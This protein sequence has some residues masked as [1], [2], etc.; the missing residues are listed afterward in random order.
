MSLVGLTRLLQVGGVVAAEAA[1][2]VQRWH[3][4]HGVG[5]R[6]A[7]I[8]A[9]AK[10]SGAKLVTRETGRFPMDDIEIVVPY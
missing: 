9:T 1:E 3:L 4:S 6:D 7:L 8:A 2:Y 10:S 5:W